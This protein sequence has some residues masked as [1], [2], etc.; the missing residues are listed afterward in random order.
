MLLEKIT[1]TKLKIFKIKATVTVRNNKSNVL[2]II[3]S[4]FYKKN[5]NYN[6]KI[7]TISK[8]NSK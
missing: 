3:T 8:K 2:Y 1:V 4:V 6:E 5:D 7:R